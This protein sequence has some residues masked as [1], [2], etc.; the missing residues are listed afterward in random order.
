MER[1]AAAPGVGQPDF[2]FEPLAEITSSVIELLLLVY[3]LAILSVV[4]MFLYY[5]I[6]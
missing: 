2:R 1:T 5:I 4:I 3:R 6:G